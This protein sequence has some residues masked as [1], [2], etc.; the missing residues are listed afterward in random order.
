MTQQK[1]IDAWV[2]WLARYGAENFA[3]SF[4]ETVENAE[5][6]CVHC[7]ERIYVDILTG[8]G[9]PDWSTEDG[10]SGCPDSPARSR[11]QSS[12]VGDQAAQTKHSCFAAQ[13]KPAALNFS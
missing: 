13:R 7:G 5:S 10:D 11:A 3:R 9:C 2:K 4:V 12:A 1:Q 6:T 8:G